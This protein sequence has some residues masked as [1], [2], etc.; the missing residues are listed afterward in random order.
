MDSDRV[1]R[2]ARVA[3]ASPALHKG[4]SPEKANAFKQAMARAMDGAGPDAPPARPHRTATTRAQGTAA[5][6]ASAA[7]M[8]QAS[9]HAAPARHADPFRDRIA[10]AEGSREQYAIR[11]SHSGALGRYQFVPQAL[12]DLGWKDANGQWTATAAAQGVTTDEQF[13]A[14]PAAQEAAMTTYLART[15][16]QLSR[17]GALA[18]AG[19]SVQGLDGGTVPLTEAG[20]M[21]AAHRRGAGSVARYLAH[22]ATTPDAT[23][24]PQ[25]RQAFA[26][27]ERRL[28][29]FSEM[30]YAMASRRGSGTPSA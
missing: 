28:R 25:Q 6:T 2:A 19:G 18:Q 1:S 10:A 11:N 20:L 29:D 21:A 23:L 12:Q 16:Q 26:S 27:V 8:L 15:E 4:A 17:N 9:R 5:S 24:S 22:R 7:L 13:L 14:N 30:P 3:A